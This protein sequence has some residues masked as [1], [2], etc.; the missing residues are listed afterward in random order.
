MA[1]ALTNLRWGAP[2]PLAPSTRVSIDYSK[3][4]MYQQSAEQIRALKIIIH[5]ETPPP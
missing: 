5:T 4:P 3:V 1:Y 2:S